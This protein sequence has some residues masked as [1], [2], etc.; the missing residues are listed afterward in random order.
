MPKIWSG[1][2]AL[3]LLL[4]GPTAAQQS[5]AVDGRSHSF[6]YSQVQRINPSPYLNPHAPA[7]PRPGVTP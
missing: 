1:A 7:P 4:A 6:D 5:I 2:L 3:V